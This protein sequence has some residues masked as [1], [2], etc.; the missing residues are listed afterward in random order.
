[1]NN[2]NMKRIRIE[3]CESTYWALFW[4][5]VG[6]TIVSFTAILSYHY[7]KRIT[8]AFDAGYQEEVL[9]GRSEFAWRKVKK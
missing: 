5:T 6:L 2:E 1:M 4:A 8:T 7:T 9:P 3:I